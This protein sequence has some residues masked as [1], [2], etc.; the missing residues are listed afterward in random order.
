MHQGLA[1]EKTSRPDAQRPAQ[2][3]DSASLF[4]KEDPA[5]RPS[6]VYTDTLNHK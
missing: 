5:A 4:T 2:R 6:S 1:I 3:A